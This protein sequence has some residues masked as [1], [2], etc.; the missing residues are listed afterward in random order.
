MDQHTHRE[1]G[2]THEDKWT[3]RRQ[4]ET[5]RHTKRRGPRERD[6]RRERDKQTE[7]NHSL[8]DEVGVE[9]LEELGAE[10]LQVVL[11]RHQALKILHWELWTY[12]NDVIKHNET[13]S[14]QVT[15]NV[16]N[17]FRLAYCTALGKRQD[18]IKDNETSSRN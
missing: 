6:R 1:K 17:S 2:Q 16:N 15:Y 8:G 10:V 5:D 18:V 7:T 13:S 4:R 11:K 3:K 14:K 9:T 12:G